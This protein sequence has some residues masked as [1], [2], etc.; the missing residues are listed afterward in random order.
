[1]LWPLV[2]RRLLLAPLAAVLIAI[3]LTA[4]GGS[5]DPLK[6]AVG[7][8]RHS[9][10]FP[11]IANLTLTGADAFGTA[12]TELHGKGV[13]SAGLAFERVDL[14]G[15]LD[16]NKRPPRDYLVVM[17]AKIYLEPAAHAALP[18]GKSW[19]T[20]P[21]PAHGAA[22]E[23]VGHFV[24]QVEGLNPR[25]LLKEIVWGATKAAKTGSTIVNHVPLVGYRVTVDLRH[26]LAAASGPADAAERIAIE[27]QLAALGSGR[28]VVQVAIQVD[29]AGFVDRLRT[30]V[31]GARL[32]SI[33]MDL[34]GYGATFRPTF[35]PAA[36]IVSLATLRSSPAWTPQSPWIL[37]AT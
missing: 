7:A 16:K 3:G 14:P 11:V 31:P 33:A 37:K 12:P 35:P 4:C 2:A 20:V 26:A 18:S 9:L 15:P 5:S 10:S 29:G 13:F 22:S 32:G 23:D 28:S 19:V 25:L 27:Q 1:M 21:L 6:S 30:T 36:Q 24:M 17:P 8:A 34:T